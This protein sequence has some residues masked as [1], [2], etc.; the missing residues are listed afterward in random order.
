MTKQSKQYLIRSYQAFK[1][2][3]RRVPFHPG[4]EQ[5]HYLLISSSLS[6]SPTT[7]QTQTGNT[8]RTG[9]RQRLWKA[10]RCSGLRNST[11]RTAGREPWERSERQKGISTSE[12]RNEAKCISFWSQAFG[13]ESVDERKP[14]LKTCCWD[15][16]KQRA[17]G[18]C[19]LQLCYRPYRGFTH[20]TLLL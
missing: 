13:W 11:N 17:N 3:Q 19:V 20:T 10:E 7:G 2:S 15:W 8:E 16:L 6:H 12:T 5:S 18:G 4:E 9:E 1:Y 14:A